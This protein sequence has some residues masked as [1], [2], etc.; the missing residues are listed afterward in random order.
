M[1]SERITVKDLVPALA[2]IG[3]IY[4]TSKKKRLASGRMSC[5]YF[6][7]GDLIISFPFEKQLV[8]D[9]LVQTY[10]DSKIKSDRLIG[11]PEG[12]NC[13]VSSLADRLGIGQLRVREVM[14]NHGDQKSIEG[15]FAKDQT[16]AVFEDVMSTGEST[17]KR[18]IVPLKESNLI[19]NAVIALIDREYG[20]IPM[21]RN[22]LGLPSVAF[23]TTS[24][25]ADELVRLSVLN[26]QQHRLLQEELEELKF[27]NSR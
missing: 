9:A 6:N 18:A 25:I 13:L 7:V 15:N 4:L 19:P 2:D 8:V 26:D 10:L 22:K 27:L 12:M 11:V 14:T 17:V 21:I 16:V 20:G 23:T 5:L 24:E 1:T 3:A